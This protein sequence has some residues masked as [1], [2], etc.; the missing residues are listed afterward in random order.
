MELNE[1]VPRRAVLKLNGKE[2]HLRPI[3]LADELWLKDRFGDSLEASLNEGKMRDVAAIVFHQIEEQDKKDF[4]AQEVTIM[5]ENGEMETMRLGGERL[6]FSLIK[7]PNDKLEMYKALM[8]T[9]GV[10]APLIDEISQAQKKSLPENPVKQSGKTSLTSSP[11]NTGGRRNT[12]WRALG[13]K[14]I[15]GLGQ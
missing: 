8:I 15:G 2:Y 5:D 1:I 14:L 4:A 3:T 9:L 13:A 11:K 12:R 7:G 6:L 10:S